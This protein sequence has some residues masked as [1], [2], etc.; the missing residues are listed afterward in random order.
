MA[1]SASEQ[2]RLESARVYVLIPA[3]SGRPPGSV[4]AT[5]LMIC[6]TRTTRTWM[7]RATS[8]RNSVMKLSVGASAKPVATRAAVEGRL[9]LLAGDVEIGDF[10]VDGE[11]E[12]VGVVGHALAVVALGPAD[13]DNGMQDAARDGGVR[14]RGGSAGSWWTM[15]GMR[16]VPKNSPVMSSL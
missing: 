5:W 7:W 10:G 4:L 3:L 15:D 1:Y 8:G 6:W 14:H 11:A 9:V 16:K 12:E 13:L 2:Q